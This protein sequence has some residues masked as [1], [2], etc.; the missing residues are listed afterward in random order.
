MMAFLLGKDFHLV[1][2]LVH[3]SSSERL[4][5][6]VDL[7]FSLF[8]SGCKVLCD[9]PDVGIIL[10]VERGIE[11]GMNGLLIGHL[12]EGLRDLFGIALLLCH[13]CQGIVRHHSCG[14]SLGSS[15]A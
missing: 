5:K 3:A 6:L 9:L 4:G 12:Y 11:S 1:S 13:T 2:S 10:A 14:F 7:F 8:L 15:V